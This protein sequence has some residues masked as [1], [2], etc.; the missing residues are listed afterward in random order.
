ML[1]SYVPEHAQH[2]REVA[3]RAQALLEHSSLITAGLDQLIY[4]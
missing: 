4:M 3:Q 1:G 2:V